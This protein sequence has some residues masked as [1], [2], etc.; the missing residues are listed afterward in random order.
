MWIFITLDFSQT[1]SG[2]MSKDSFCKELLK[3]GFSK[4][5]RNTWVRYCTT[6][7]NA[8]M[9]RERVKRLIPLRSCVTLILVA[10]K[11]CELMYNYYGRC[12]RRKKVPQMPQPI[13]MIEFF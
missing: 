7:G 5:N 10:D 12:L 6:L 8:Q 4:L 2:R 1:H 13:D 9:H 3:D 11:Q